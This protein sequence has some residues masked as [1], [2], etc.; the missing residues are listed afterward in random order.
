ME[1]LAFSRPRNPDL[2]TTQLR[3]DAIPKVLIDVIDGIAR[4]R[5]ETRS[6][7]VIDI[8]EQWA[9]LRAREI[10]FVQRII[11]SNAEISELA[12]LEEAQ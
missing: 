5:G 12:G 11:R 6:S 2:P 1:V 9:Q 7:L 10:T 4:A 8:L 3:V